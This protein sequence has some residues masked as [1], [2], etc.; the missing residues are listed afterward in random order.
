MIGLYLQPY[1]TRVAR[2]LDVIEDHA[3]PGIENVTT[4]MTAGM[5]QMRKHVVCYVGS[6]LPFQS[7][8]QK[9]PHNAL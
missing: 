2:S 3:L 4:K 6:R 5:G 7:G 1:R 8:E 9:K